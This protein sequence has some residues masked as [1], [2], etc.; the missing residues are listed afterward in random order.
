MYDMKKKMRMKAMDAMAMEKPANLEKM[1]KM[2]MARYG[3]DEAPSEEES[4]EHE[5]EMADKEEDMSEGETEDGFISMPVTPE[6]K[7]MILAMRKKSGM[8]S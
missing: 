7:K 1:M 2:K 3:M 8:E 6:E 4:P 5:M